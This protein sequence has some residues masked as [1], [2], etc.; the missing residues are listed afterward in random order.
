[1]T[2]TSAHGRAIGTW[3]TAAR[4]LVGGY[5]VGSVVVGSVTGHFRVESWVLGLVGFPVLALGWQAW[6]ARRRPQRL[7]AYTGPLG[8]LLTLALFLL[9]Y[10]T[11]WYAP[12][13]GFVSDAALLF[14]GSSMLLAAGRGYSG[15]EVLAISNWLLRRDDQLGCVVFDAV[16]R[17]GSRR[18]V[19]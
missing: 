11:T 6:R 7:V 3:G 1:M 9:L 2:E 18:T 19:G 5:L 15:C 13:I 17:L 8:H 4:L 12:P 16:D 14:F 10:G